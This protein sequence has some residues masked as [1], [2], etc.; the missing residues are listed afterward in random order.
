[1]TSRR[2][3]DCGTAPHEPERP[4]AAPCPILWLQRR[5]NQGGRNPV[6]I[7]PGLQPS[8]FSSME[9]WPAASRNGPVASP[10]DS[11]R[12]RGPAVSPRY[13]CNLFAILSFA[14]IWCR[15]TRQPRIGPIYWRDWP[16]ARKGAGMTGRSRKM[17]LDFTFAALQDIEGR[18]RQL[19][20]FMDDLH[21]DASGSRPEEPALTCARGPGS[22]AS[23]L[24]FS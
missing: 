17:S 23:I 15:L 16:I 18:R 20:D 13:S 8:L 6:T 1:M 22:H 14:L 3:P 21:S 10:S 5:D 12:R 9:C 19:G 2:A 11:S 24:P 4:P 7:E